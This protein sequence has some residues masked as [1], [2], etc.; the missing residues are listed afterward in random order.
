MM[1]LGIDYGLGNLGFAT[2]ESPLATPHTTLHITSQKEALAQSLALVQKLKPD[3]I[4]V[5]MP[6]GELEP[7]ITAYV[8]ELQ[9][10][11][12]VTT[13]THDEAFSSYDAI[14]K[15]REAG[16]KKSKLKN[17]HAYAAC[18]ILEDYLDLHPNLV[19]L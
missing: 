17:D 3:L 13:V 16:A 15:L 6:K 10:Q 4:V 12:Q 11:T 8:R 18:L 9:Q 5:G 7:I 2:A 19:K 14:L 1:V